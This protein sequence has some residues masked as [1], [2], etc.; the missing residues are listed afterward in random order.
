MKS[1]RLD[2]R[3][4][5]PVGLFGLVVPALLL[6][7]HF[8]PATSRAAGPTRPETFPAPSPAKEDELLKE[9]R[10]IF[11]P[12]PKDQATP[13]VPAIV[14]FPGSLTGKLPETF[15]NPPV[16]PAAGFDPSSPGAGDRKG[17]PA[18]PMPPP[19]KTG[20][21]HPIIPGF[22]GVLPLPRAAEQPRKGAKVVL[23]VTATAEPVEVNPGLDRAARILNLYGAAGLNAGDVKI[24][25]VLHGGATRAVVT[26]SVYKARVGPDTNPNLALIRTLR[27]AGVEV[28]VCGQALHAAGFEE[29][30]VADSISVADAFL[31]VIVNRQMDGYVYVPG[32]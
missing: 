30:D 14:T 13:E 23:D 29:A 17:P 9:A 4:G 32:Q 19:V 28:F 20:L 21:V 15:A 5:R 3:L 26:D 2:R 1:T 7:A 16:L 12:L 18:R 22:G 8:D 11:K 24:A 31:T 27:K 6:A 10:G 25:V